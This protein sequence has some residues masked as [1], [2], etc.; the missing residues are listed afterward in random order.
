MIS[1]LPPAELDLPGDADALALQ[2]RL[3]RAELRSIASPDHSGEDLV[4]AT[5]TATINADLLAFIKG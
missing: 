4:P 3:G 1:G 2:R 5:E